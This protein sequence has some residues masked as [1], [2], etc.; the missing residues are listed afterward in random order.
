MLQQPRAQEVGIKV[1][2]VTDKNKAAGG[3]EVRFEPGERLVPQFP[4]LVSY[5]VFFPV[6]E[7]AALFQAHDGIIEDRRP[8]PLLCGE[9]RR[10]HDL[11]GYHR[12]SDYD[13]TLH[14]RLRRRMQDSGG[15]GRSAGA[16][17]LGGHSR[18][19]N[20]GYVGAGG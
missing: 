6:V 1:Q 18:V 5:V 12:V 17:I 13:T 11:V 7:D 16:V 2:G 19:G 4:L 8:Q 3:G 10:E 9:V 15:K 14:S 20:V